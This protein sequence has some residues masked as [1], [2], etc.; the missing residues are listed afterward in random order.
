[1]KKLIVARHAERP[2]IPSN[3]VG[4]DVMLTE[5]GIE[6]SKL[7]A[8]LIDLPLHSVKSSPIGRCIQTANVIAQSLGFRVENIEQCKSLG[9]PGFIIQDSELAWQHWLDKGH[10]AVNQHL[11]SGKEKW[12]GFHDLDH[13]C[14]D[15]FNTIKELLSNSA[16]G[17]HLWITHDTILATLASRIN[18]PN[19]TLNDW[20]HF[21]GY[22]IFT[23][24]NIGDIDIDY[25]QFPNF[26][27]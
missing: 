23:Y 12:A 17:T 24:S 11:I 14:N 19:F 21:L 5:K 16:Y 3:T 2:E 25:V 1:M 8:S 9:D 10:D 18:N 27:S 13:I 6:Q 4:N 7:F 20:P 22:M 26:S 15:I